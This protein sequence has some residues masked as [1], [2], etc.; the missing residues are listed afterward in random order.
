MV[1]GDCSYG[2]RHMAAEEMMEIIHS[3]RGK[4]PYPDELEISGSRS[5]EG[6]PITDGLTNK[7]RNDKFESFSNRPKLVPTHS[8]SSVMDF[9]DDM[10]FRDGGGRR[11]VTWAQPSVVTEV[12]YRRRVTL[13]EK[14]VLFYT[15]NDM[16]RFRKDAKLAMKMA[17][18]QRLLSSSTT[19]SQYNEDR[20]SNP[21]VT[22]PISSLVNE[23]TAYISWLLTP[24]ERSPNSRSSNNSITESTNTLIETLYLF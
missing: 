12:R 5:G 4:I 21:E 23:T 18:A 2:D 7:E 10:N 19:S 8:F 16:R 11:S 3:S 1:S 6:G 15:E 24:S 14:Q 22:S 20:M 13:V 9:R 17:H